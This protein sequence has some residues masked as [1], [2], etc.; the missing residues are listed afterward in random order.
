MT[1]GHDAFAPQPHVPSG[2]VAPEVYSMPREP[3]YGLHIGLRT[4]C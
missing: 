1:N 4:D 2:N 3:M